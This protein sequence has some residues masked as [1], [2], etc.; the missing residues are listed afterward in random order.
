[1]ARPLLSVEDARRADARGLEP[2]PSEE[3]ALDDAAGPSAAAEV[4]VATTLPPWDNSAMDGFAVRSRPISQR[5]ESPLR[6]TVRVIAAGRD[7]P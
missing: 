5:T 6:V 2:L 7:A 4:T 1:M 3:V